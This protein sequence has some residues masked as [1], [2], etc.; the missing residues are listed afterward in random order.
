MMVENVNETVDF[1]REVLGFNLVMTVPDSGAFDWALVKREEVEVM[2]QAR[3]SLTEEVPLFKDKP[4]GGALT[5]FIRMQG[6][7]DLY[8]QIHPKVNVVQDLHTTFYGTREFAIQDCN[9]FVL[10]FAEPNP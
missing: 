4:V 8:R 7:E 1:Y 2:F 5:F 3:A 6:V 9:G 10:T